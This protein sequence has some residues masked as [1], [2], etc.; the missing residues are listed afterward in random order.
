MDQEKEM[1]FFI[2]D[3]SGYTAYMLAN[4][5]SIEHAKITITVIIES[6]VKQIHLPLKIA[7]LEGDAIF[8]YLENHIG[9]SEWL[10]NKI[11]NFFQIFEEKIHELQLSSTC[12]CGACI[13]IEKLDLKVIVHFGKASIQKIGRFKELSGLDVI[14]VHRLL[15]NSVK[16]NRY[17]LLTEAAYQHMSF[18]CSMQLSKSQE[19]CE[20]IGNFV[21]Y[22]GEP[23]H[24]NIEDL[25]DYTSF[26]YKAKRWISVKIKGTFYKL[27]RKENT[28][29]NLPKN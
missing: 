3:I 17:L 13:N 2:A 16:L 14:I 29:R 27:F 19:I 23:P 20:D 12:A 18:P 1:F 25:P 28:F 11:I 9:D 8:L 5:L 7:K 10:C 15:K 21:T 6:L 22:V 24:I 26:F 4:K